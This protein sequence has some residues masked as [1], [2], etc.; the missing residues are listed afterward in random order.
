MSVNPHLFLLSK[1]MRTRST[2]IN[3]AVVSMTVRG[4]GG[5]FHKPDPKPW[6]PYNHTRVVALEDINTVFYHDTNP[7]YYLH[8]H[9][10]WVKNAR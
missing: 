7:E 9:S 5:H 10:M 8:L 2:L 4:G 1:A 6:K 3:P